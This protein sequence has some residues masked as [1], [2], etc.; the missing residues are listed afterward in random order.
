M[1]WTKIPDTPYELHP[2]GIVRRM[3]D[4][5]W[6]YCKLGPCASVS[7]YQNDG[8][9][10][11][12]SINTILKEVFPDAPKVRMMDVLRVNDEVGKLNAA[13][14]KKEK[15]AQKPYEA[16]N[17]PEVERRKCAKKGCERMGSGYWCAKHRA[18][19]YAEGAAEYGM[20]TEEYCLP[21]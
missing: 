16:S 12:C 7:I 21:W 19:K 15:W 8:S 1:T 20:P 14:P 17:G 6:R 11:N 3:R 4:G 9:Q 18:E 2:D 5:S 13:R 10:R